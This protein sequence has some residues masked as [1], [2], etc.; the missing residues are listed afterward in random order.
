MYCGLGSEVKLKVHWVV[1]PVQAG[2]DGWRTG[3][4]LRV[5]D[6]WLLVSRLRGNDEKGSGVSYVIRTNIADKRY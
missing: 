2:N 3:A 5:S 1:I 4:R 6:G